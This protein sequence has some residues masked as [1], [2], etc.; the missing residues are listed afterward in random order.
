MTW[1]KEPPKEN[2]I[3]ATRLGA[4]DADPPPREMMPAPKAPAALT[5]VRNFVQGAAFGLSDEA[6]GL[7][8]GAGRMV[9]LRG[10]GGPLKDV[11]V[12]EGGPTI[13]A[14]VLRAAY[15][16]GRNAERAALAQDKKERPGLSS[17][18]EIA[19]MVV[20]PV[21]RIARGMSALKGGAALGGIQGFGTS[22]ADDV[23]GLVRDA[24]TGAVIGG[25]VGKAFDVAAPVVAKVAQN[26]GAKLSDAAEK[27]AYVSAGPMLKDFRNSEARKS[28]NRTGRYILDKV[29]LKVG[30]SVDDVAR[31]AEAIRERAGQNLD[32]VYTEA[33]EKMGLSLDRV[34]FDPKRDKAEVLMAAARELG[35]TVGAKSAL[36]KLSSYFDELIARH[37]D[38]P[39]EEAAAA[40]R[41]AVAEYLP[42]FRQYAKDRAAYRK[43]VGKAGEDAA[44]PILPGFVDDLQRTGSTSRQ[45]E[46]AGKP[47]SVPRAES[48]QYTTQPDLPNLPQRPQGQFNP[49]RGDDLL[50]LQQQLALDDIARA[51]VPQAARQAEIEGLELTPRTY[52]TVEQPAVAGPKGQTS[53]PFEPNAPARPV[54]P[55][56]R[57]NPLAPREANNVKSAIDDE[58]NYAR[59][60]LTKEPATEKAFQAAR[61]VISQKVDE[62]IE[63][64]GGGKLLEALKQA[65]RDY[66]ASKEIERMAKDRA[67]RNSANK[68]LGLTDSIAGTGAAVYGATTGDWQGA[69][70]AFAGKKGLEKFGASTLAVGADRLSKFLLRSPALREIAQNNPQAYSAVILDLTERLER[71]GAL[72]KA[73]DE[74]PTKGPEKWARVGA[75]RLKEHGVSP[76]EVEALRQTE[77][78][79]DL[80]NRASDLKPGSKAMED[81]VKRMKTATARGGEE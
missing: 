36:N 53:M 50:P 78:G 81:I 71:R 56:D 51:E 70:T 29:G 31:K 62:A 22:E 60:P 34:G 7:V 38:K 23:G 75:E 6:A 42:K 17:A 59:N 39:A 77:K 63:S 57:R 9:G 58:I 67:L 24:A 72:P 65:N 5:G 61:K 33:A 13:D 37:A 80:L 32:Q 47:A 45:I 44:Q 18:S 64:L 48:P 16:E 46:V 27:I 76:A 55:A 10:L 69:A 3:S 54:R 66:G 11:Q 19:G 28:I 68:F 40:Y 35:D 73:A 12:A 20:S 8:E 21:N 30:D 1:D 14:D 25:S 52:R 2:E 4:W 15:E 43:A 74:K 79:R 41:Q 26:A 49:A